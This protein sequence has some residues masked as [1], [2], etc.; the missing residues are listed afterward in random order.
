MKQSFL[1]NYVIITMA[2]SAILTIFSYMLLTWT[3]KTIPMELTALLGSFSGGSVMSNVFKATGLKQELRVK[4]SAVDY[5]LMGLAIAMVTA[6]INYNLLIWADR[7]TPAQMIVAINSMEAIVLSGTTFR[8][9]N[10]VRSSPLENTDQ[11]D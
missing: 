8:N 10:T 5:A 3:N 7:E 9:S 11:K 1:A 4:L 6:V 2:T